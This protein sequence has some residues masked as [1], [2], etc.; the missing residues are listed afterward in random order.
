MRCVHLD[1]HT[2][3]AI[4]GI[5][6]RFNKKKFTE[7]VKNAKIELMTVFAKCHHVCGKLR[8]FAVIASARR[9]VFAKACCGAGVRFFVCVED[10]ASHVCAHKK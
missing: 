7:T 2:S 3:P 9:Q 8:F 4:A 1:F 10:G 5:G 6:E